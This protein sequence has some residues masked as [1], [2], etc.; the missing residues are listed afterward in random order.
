MTYQEKR[1]IAAHTIKRQRGEGSN[2]LSTPQ[3]EGRRRRTERVDQALAPW[4]GRCDASPVRDKKKRELTIGGDH[5]GANEN[6]AKR[7]N[8]A[9]TEGRPEDGTRG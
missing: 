4:Q 3:K 5:G 9:P 8:S 6:G 7:R 1:R 2:T